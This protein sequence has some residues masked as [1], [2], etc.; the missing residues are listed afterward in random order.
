MIVKLFVTIVLLLE[1]SMA[2]ATMATEGDNLAQV[3]ATSFIDDAT[4]SYR[5]NVT[6]DLATLADTEF[7]LRNPADAVAI[8]PH[9]QIL[10]NTMMMPVPEPTALVLLLAGLVAIGAGRFAAPRTLLFK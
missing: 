5:D 9:Q 10:S 3:A 2:H 8:H 1:M 7:G 4:F 6:F